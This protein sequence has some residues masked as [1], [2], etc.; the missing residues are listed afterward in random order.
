MYISSMMS[1]L[2]A[3]KKPVV[4]FKP[5]RMGANMMSDRGTGDLDQ[6]VRLKRG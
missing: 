5:A 2:L 3:L 6:I 1:V 4:G